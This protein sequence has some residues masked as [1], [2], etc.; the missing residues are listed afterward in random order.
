MR[1]GFSPWVGKI[2]WR[3]KCQPTPV[4]LPGKS[5]RQ[6]SL[7]GY[8]PWGRRELDMTEWR[9]FHFHFMSSLEKCLFRASAHFSFGLFVFSVLS[10]MS[11]LCILEFNPLSVASFASIFPHPIGWLFALVIVSFAVQKLVSLIRPHLFSFV[12]ISITLGDGSKNI[13][14]WWIHLILKLWNSLLC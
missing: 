3:R 11:Y 9:H 6:S 8:S 13:L 1:P 7:V 4:L 2:P 14:L 10:C 5:H 12:F